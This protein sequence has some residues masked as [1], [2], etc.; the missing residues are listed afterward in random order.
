MTTGES[1]APTIQDVPPLADAALTAY[2]RPLREVEDEH[3]QFAL[4]ACHGNKKRAAEALGISRDTL[5][6]KLA[7]LAERVVEPGTSAPDSQ[8]TR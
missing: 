6:R 7:D 8:E 4:R 2:V 3:V 1:S 5:Y